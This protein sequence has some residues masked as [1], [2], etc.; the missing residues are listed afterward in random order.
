MAV[1]YCC[2]SIEHWDVNNEQLHGF[3]FELA[4][5][6][7]WI[8][9]YMFNGVRARDADVTLFLNDYNIVNLGLMTQVYIIDKCQL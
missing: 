3:F 4:S 6:D 2:F 9:S 8:L 5:G 7:P 1:S